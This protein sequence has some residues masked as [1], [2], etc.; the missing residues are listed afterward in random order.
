M[1][2]EKN[3]KLIL[4]KGYKFGF[5]KKLANDTDRWTCVKKNL[6]RI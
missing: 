1:Y 6:S 4:L 3:K 5:Q 2:S